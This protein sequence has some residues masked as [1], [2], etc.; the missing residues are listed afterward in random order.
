MKK[1]AENLF[2]TRT[3]YVLELPL[4]RDVRILHPEMVILKIGSRYRDVGALCYALRS[5]KKRRP[6]QPAQ[7]VLSS[8]LKHRP[9][10]ILQAIK[11]LSA[12]VKGGRTSTAEQ[13][14]VC[15]QDLLGWTDANGHLDCLAG[16]EDTRRAFRAYVAYVEERYRQQEIGVNTAYRF[17][18]AA[19]DM[20]QAI[21]GIEDLARGVRTIQV[22]RDLKT[23]T[24]PAADHDFAHML[25]MSHALFDGICD[26]VLDNR[27]FP[28][29]L[30]LPKSVG[31][32]S[33]HL[34]LFPTNVWR[35]PP[36]KWDAKSC[37]PYDYQHGRLATVDEIWH[38]Y[39][40]PTEVIKRNVA[41]SV[42]RAA[43][44]RIDCA[45][46]DHRDRYRV[47]LGMFA[48]NAFCF[49][50]HANSGGNQQPILDLETDG[51]LEVAIANQGFRELKFRA[52][53]KEV[54]IP[55]PAS[56]IPSLR[57]FIQLRDWLLNGA[58]FPY[59]FMTFGS[60]SDRTIFPQKANDKI[61]TGHNDVLRRI[62]PKLKVIR[63]RVARATMDD[64]LLRKYEAKIAAVVM[65][66][67]EATEL[68]KYGRG[69]EV[70]FRDDMT[71]FLSR[72]SAAAKKQAVIS[73]RSDLDKNARKLEQGGNCAHFGDPEPMT[74]DPNLQPDCAGGCWFC[75]H[76]MLVADEEDTRKVA[77]A[78]FVMDQL[79]LGPQHEVALRPLIDK[80][81]F[82]LERIAQTGNCRP[83]VE[84][85]RR[86][87][88]EDG[89]LTPYWAEKYHLFLELEVIA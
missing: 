41:K 2:A 18:K 58:S 48:H 19:R 24:E 89:N 46:A 76:R 65:G 78:A 14:S 80:C 49:L 31:W 67:S 47:M 87:V 37:L 77:S 10:Q 26:L 68:K 8:L 83:M 79:T 82:D 12:A 9:K 72:V 59:L 73:V 17:Q 30:V 69:S 3:A 39:K 86:D 33:N 29:K 85:V 51:T 6:G 75:A 20:L 25:A 81:D 11:V 42:I 43:K 36:H 44:R 63:A 57:R 28:Y 15:L 4:V 66:H 40:A 54:F 84:R 27:P 60:K 55:I 21:T 70:D 32:E 5:D 88:Y 62:D 38:R 64:W 16:G 52:Y 50:L 71:V 61:L 45:N 7:V 53:G 35:L 23:G 34:W 1:A 56:F 22:T 74:D 13:A